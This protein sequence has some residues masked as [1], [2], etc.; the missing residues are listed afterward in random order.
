MAKQESFPLH[1]PDQSHFPKTSPQTYWSS[2]PLK[3]ERDQGLDQRLLFLELVR[4]AHL[5]PQLEL[6]DVVSILILP[7]RHRR[8]TIL[9][10]ELTKTNRIMSKWADYGISAVKYNA[11]HT[12]IVK[13]KAR[14]DNGDTI[15]SPSEQ[16]RQ[17][18]IAAI[19]K[20]TT[21]V[22][23]TKNADSEWAKIQ[24]IVLNTSIDIV[25]GL[26]NA[27]DT[28]DVIFNEAEIFTAQLDL[29]SVGRVRVL[30]MHEGVVGANSAVK[31]LMTTGD[32][33][34]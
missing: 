32:N 33:V 21:Y 4:R 20:G 19:K 31:V 6:A 23:I 14:R 16:T 3:A 17:N 18:V 27:K 9:F 1:P 30:F 15:G 12:H 10:C 34:T 13:V 5:R 7:C 28:A 26:T 22:T 11:E 24:R 25:D 29:S 2:A 8:R